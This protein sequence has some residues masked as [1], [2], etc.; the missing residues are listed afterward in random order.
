MQAVD[1]FLAVLAVDVGRDVVHRARSVERHHGDDVLEAVRLQPLQAFAHAGAFELEHACR[2]GARQE[3]VGPA[4]VERYFGEIDVDAARPFHETERL[5]Q[6]GQRLEAEE[7]ELHEAGRLDHLPVELRD[8]EMRFRIAIERNELFQ[9][10]VGNDDA[11]GMRRGV[12]IEA[13]ELLRDL[14]E[15]RHDR[16]ALLLLLQFRL[17]VDCVLQ[18]DRVRRIVRH[19]LAQPVHLAVRHLQ[20]AADVAQHGARLQLAVGDDLGDAVGAIL[21]LDV[22]D[23]AIALFLAEVDVEVRH[24]DALG[25]EEALEQQAEPQ[26]VEIGD[27]QR[28]GDERA[29]T[30]SAPRPDGH[31]VRL[32]P[33]DEVGDDQKVA[34]ELH[35]RDD[36]DFVVEAFAVVVL[37][38]PRRRS[39][40]GETQIEAR[41][42]LTLQLGGFKA[43]ILDL[44]QAV[45]A[46]DEARQYRLAA[47]RPKG[48]AHR[49]LRQCAR[50][51]RGDRRTAPPSRL[52]IFR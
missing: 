47:R 18:R 20:H 9:R 2:V 52:P 31:A 25:V 21:L 30:R 15:P 7:V 37:G 44:A 24:R 4:V 5:L 33:L 12:A 26:R 39:P 22:I 36:V 13:L 10:P 32:R 29:R 42:R 51:P 34:G 23:D 45:V 27:G 1:R 41:P 19:E 6:N 8:R 17:A 46:G 16:L 28:V 35:L 14:E 38:E 50:A 11:G 40:R 43:K 48:T 49:D 3:L